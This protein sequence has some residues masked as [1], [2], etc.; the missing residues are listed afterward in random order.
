M[1]EEMPDK[2]RWLCL[3]SGHGETY[4]TR[5]DAGQIGGWIKSLLAENTRLT[6]AFKAAKAFIESHAADPDIT[7]EMVDKFSKYLEAEDALDFD[8][9][10][11][12]NGIVD[13]D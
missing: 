8:S 11:H 10:R 4:L 2:V 7:A 5:E 3:L 1:S 12:D 6:N 9:T 13:Y